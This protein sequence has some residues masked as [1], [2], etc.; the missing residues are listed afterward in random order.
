MV[1]GSF[2]HLDANPAGA[3]GQRAREELR[4]YLTY[5]LAQFS[6]FDA[7]FVLDREGAVRLWVGVERDLSEDFR[8]QLAAVDEMEVS[9]AN[10]T[11]HTLIQ[12]VSSRDA[13]NPSGMSLH[14]LVPME[15]VRGLLMSDGLEESGA[16]FVVD[17]SGRVLMASD[18]AD[19]PERYERE[20]P[21]SSEPSGLETYT[22]PGGAEVVGVARS[23]G[24]FGW[25]V[26][27]EESYEAAFAPV[28]TVVRG[29]LG[30]TWRSSRS[31]AWRRCSPRARWWARSWPSPTASGA[32]P[33]GCGHRHP[34]P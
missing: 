20:L 6:E 23:L 25:T 33:R 30:S 18:G 15:T 17:A 4:T 27:V 9:S 29:I 1:R 14:G 32:S 24:R 5:V 16:V 21:A 7:L 22:R 31:S 8:R 26:V 2:R 13:G 12:V 11:D 3:R 10:G 34:G 28:V 19:A